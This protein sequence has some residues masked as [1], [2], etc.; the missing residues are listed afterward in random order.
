MTGGC[1]AALSSSSVIGGVGEMCRG[2]SEDLGSVVKWIADLAAAMLATGRRQDE[3]ATGRIY[4][5][6]FKPKVALAAVKDEET[7]ANDV[8]AGALGRV[9]CCPVQGDDRPQ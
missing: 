3:Q 6:A 1:L 8:L 5:P 4:S 9:V 2:G 7:P